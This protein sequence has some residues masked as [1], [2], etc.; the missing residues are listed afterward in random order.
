MARAGEAKAQSKKPENHGKTSKERDLK[1]VWTQSQEQ[2]SPLHACRHKCL[3]G[4]LLGQRRDQPRVCWDAPCVIR[5]RLA[6]ALHLHRGFTN[7]FKVTPS[8]SSREEELVL[9]SVSLN[10]LAGMAS[11]MVGQRHVLRMWTAG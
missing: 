10:V 6:L 4:V 3:Y 2:I 8:S 1:E 7:T 5:G 9:H 11:L